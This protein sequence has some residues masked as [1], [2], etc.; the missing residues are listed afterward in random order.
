MR[1]PSSF[2]SLETHPSLDRAQCVAIGERLTAARSARGLTVDEASRTLLLSPRQVRALES[3]EIQAFHNES[4]YLG[5]LRKYAAFCGLDDD[6]LIRRIESTRVESV[7]TIERP[8]PSVPLDDAGESLRR[9]GIISAVIVALIVVA[10]VTWNLTRARS[11]SLAATTAV[12]SNEPATPPAATDTPE[13]VEAPAAAPTLAP[14]ETAGPVEPVT[15]TG[16]I[17][18]AGP[19][20]S[21]DLAN[22]EPTIPEPQELAPV[23]TPT[24]TYGS[25]RANQ[26]AWMFLRQ[27]DNSV[28][29]RTLAPGE[30]VHLRAKPRYLALGSSEVDLTIGDVTVDIQ[31]FVRNGTLRMG[32]AE[33]TTAEEGAG[34]APVVDTPQDPPGGS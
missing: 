19:S 3:F 27:S 28:I 24:T 14:S 15:T 26:K 1:S 25:F 32:V 11:F 30:V 31:K 4:F 12:V 5:A 16:P 7:E 10:G 23:L 13:A 6:S 34:N 29:E 33:F 20:A 17:P 21:A 18:D 2:P 22:G 9:K 8:R